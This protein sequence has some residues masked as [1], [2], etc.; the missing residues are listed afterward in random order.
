LKTTTLVAIRVGGLG[1]DR[2]LLGGHVVDEVLTARLEVRQRRGVRLEGGL[3]G[4]GVVAEGAGDHA[5]LVHGADHGRRLGRLVDAGAREARPGGRQVGH[6]GVGG[7]ADV[8]ERA[9]GGLDGGG[10]RQHR[11]LSGA[12][13][14]APRE[15]SIAISWSPA[16]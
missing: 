12:H 4:R 8:A 11:E 10:A 16:S 6:D 9:G 5:R 15:F 7:G 2:G 14:L 3:R 13:W 1:G